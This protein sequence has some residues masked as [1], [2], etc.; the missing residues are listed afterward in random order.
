MKKEVLRKCAIC[1]KNINIL[2]DDYLKDNKRFKHTECF[3]EK[4]LNKCNKRLSSQAIEE[5]IQIIKNNMKIEQEDIDRQQ[6]ELTNK[7]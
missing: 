4:E 2:K 5:K 1:E 6:L 7:K 3:R